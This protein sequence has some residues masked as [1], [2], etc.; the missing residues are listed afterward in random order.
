[1]KKFLVFLLLFLSSTALVACGTETIT[2]TEGLEY[3]VLE[4]GTYEVS[5]IGTASDFEIVI[6]AEYNGKPV[7]S[8]ADSA[9]KECYNL[10]SVV[11][12]NGISSIGQGAFS[13]CTSLS[14]VTLP[15]TLNSVGTGAFLGCD[16]LAY[17]E[18][19]NAKY[20]G[21][22]DNPYLALISSKGTDISSCKVNKNTKFICSN[23]F[24]LCSSLTDIEIPSGVTYIGSAAF[25][26]C[27][28]LSE[29]EL[30]SK[31]TVIE[32]ACF[33]GCSSLSSVNVPSNVSSIGANAFEGCTALT[34][35]SLPKSLKTIEFFAFSN[36]VSLKKIYIPDS[37]STVEACVFYSCS[38]LAE[39]NCEADM[40]GESWA[41]DWLENCEAELKF[42]VK[43]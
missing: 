8:V 35:I 19:D 11:I 20:L 15:K 22:S 1:M 25:Q 38:G 42:G 28:S 3:K 26:G 10:K 14:T 34:S 4:N 5:G 2:P 27:F 31:I 13:S 40:Q 39:I 21:S 33:A 6:P 9:F 24:F 18:Y 43:K 7:S 36:C 32:D 37:V 17:N 30:P 23:A 12:S 16:S 41:I 29:I